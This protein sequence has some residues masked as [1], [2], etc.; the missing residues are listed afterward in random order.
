MTAT[1]RKFARFLPE[2]AVAGALLLSGSW[3]WSAT[4]AP[5]AQAATED[6]PAPPKAVAWKPANA[7]QRA[8]SSQAIRA[9]LELFKKGDWE[10][11]VAYQSTDLKK[12]FPS[13]AAFRAMMVSTYP[14]FAKY[15]KIEFGEARA[16]GPVVQM[17]IKLTGSDNIVVRAVYIMVKEKS[18]YKVAS[19]GG[20]FPPNLHEGDLA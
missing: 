4:F 9:Q 12:N 1:R 11:A 2:I 7:A 18:G 3:L 10:K 20:G 17:A 8:G 5:D 15:K 19:V 13:T 6:R 14:Q 16:A